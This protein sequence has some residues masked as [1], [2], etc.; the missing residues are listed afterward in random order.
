MLGTVLRDLHVIN[1]YLHAFVRRHSHSAWFH[2][3][4]GTRSQRLGC[5]DLCI[6]HPSWDPDTIFCV[7]GMNHLHFTD[8]ETEA[9]SGDNLL[10]TLGPVSG[11]TKP[12]AQ[13]SRLLVL[14]VFL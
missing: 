13:V 7:C 8:E 5:I 2:L 11:R 4:M 1:M 9:Q 14:L 6:A 10:K 3:G 12:A